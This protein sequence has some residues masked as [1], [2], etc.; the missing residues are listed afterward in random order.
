M[1]C[2]SEK[3]VMDGY[4]AA[5]GSDHSQSLLSDYAKRFKYANGQYA[6]PAPPVCHARWSDQAWIDYIDACGTWN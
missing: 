4:C 1:D 6:C 2:C 3:Y 5:C